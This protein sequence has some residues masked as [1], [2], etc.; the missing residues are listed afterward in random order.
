MKTLNDLGLCKKSRK[1]V[2]DWLQGW[3]DLF[4]KQANGTQGWVYRADFEKNDFFFFTDCKDILEKDPESKGQES[5]LDIRSRKRKIMLQLLMKTL[6]GQK[7]TNCIA[8]CSHCGFDPCL[9]E[10][11]KDGNGHWSYCPKCKK[12]EVQVF[13]EGFNNCMNTI[14]MEIAKKLA[15]LNTIKIHPEYKKLMTEKPIEK[16]K[17][18]LTSGDK[19]KIKCPKCGYKVPKKSYGNY[20][21][22]QCDHCYFEENRQ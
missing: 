13:P 4:V 9:L 12:L 10:A 16:V 21:T 15:P 8:K 5:N 7:A 14:R 18:I 20:A 3:L 11:L 22:G 17:Q 2:E 1:K 6:L 19:E